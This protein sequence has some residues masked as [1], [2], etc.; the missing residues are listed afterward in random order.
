LHQADVEL[1]RLRLY[2]RLSHEF[3]LFNIGQYEY[4]FKMVIEIGKLLGGWA[5]EK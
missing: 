4:V 5:K 1:Q 2:L 3:Q